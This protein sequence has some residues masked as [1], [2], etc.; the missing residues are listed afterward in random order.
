MKFILA[1]LV[2]ATGSGCASQL[3]VG[4]NDASIALFEVDG[5]T[6]AP[7]VTNIN[8]DGCMLIVRNLKLLDETNQ[9]L[10]SI[11]MKTSTCEFGEELQ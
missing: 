8:A 2:V 10:E 5:N 9:S 3:D 11:R 6:G 4:Q 7:G 1:L